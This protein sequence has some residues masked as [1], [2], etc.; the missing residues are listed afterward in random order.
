MLLKGG[1]VIKSSAMRYRALVTD[2]NLKDKLD[3]WHVAKKV[4]EIDPAFL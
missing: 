3:G 2:I 1:A 4:R